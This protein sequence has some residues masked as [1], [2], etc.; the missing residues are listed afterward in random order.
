MTM[1]RAGAVA[2]LA[3]TGFAVVYTATTPG[4]LAWFGLMPVVPMTVISCVLML[5]VSLVTPLPT[6][7]TIARYS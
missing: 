6:A 5:V 7:P 3:I 2:A 4:A 1:S